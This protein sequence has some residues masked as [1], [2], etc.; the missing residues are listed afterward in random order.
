[1]GKSE[2][3]RGLGINEVLVFQNVGILKSGRQNINSTAI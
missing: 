2:E 3:I 1:V